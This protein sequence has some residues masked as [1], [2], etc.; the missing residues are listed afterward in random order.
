M[1]LVLFFVTRRY[2]GSGVQSN[3]NLIALGCSSLERTVRS[4]GNGKT[5]FGIVLYTWSAL[6]ID[7]FF[8]IN[9][10]YKFGT[11]LFYGNQLNLSL[12]LVTIHNLLDR[13]FKHTC[14]IIK[15]DKLQH[16]RK[17]EI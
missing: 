11:V 1:V 17:T 6:I 9:D 13:F 7:F 15:Q 4:F 3:F 10:L 16:L 5:M 8:T 2:Y 12:D 14:N